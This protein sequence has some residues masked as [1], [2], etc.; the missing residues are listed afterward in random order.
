LLFCQETDQTKIEQRDKKR[1]GEK[2]RTDITLIVFLLL[3]STLI[4][5][6][7]VG[8]P[9]DTKPGKRQNTKK[10]RDQPLANPIKLKQVSQQKTVCHLRP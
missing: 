10:E 3:N 1:K 9:T 8:I 4:N 7:I 5:P 6:V 2:T